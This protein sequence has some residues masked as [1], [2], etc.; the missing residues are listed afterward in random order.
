MLANTTTVSQQTS[1]DVPTFTAYASGAVLVTFGATVSEESLNRA[2]DCV[3]EATLDSSAAVVVDLSHL[4]AFPSE[5]VTA[6]LRAKARNP[7]TELS[8][9]GMEPTARG[10]LILGTVAR[11]KL[12]QLR[13]LPF[14]VQEAGE[15]PGREFRWS[16]ISALSNL[17]LGRPLEK[18]SC[19]LAERYSTLSQGAASAAPIEI[20]ALPPRAPLDFERTESQDAVSIK[21][22]SPPN[23]D[24]ARATLGTII[25]HLPDDRQCVIDIADVDAQGWD[26]TATVIMACK[27]RGSAGLPPVVVRAGPNAGALLQRLLGARS[28]AATVGRPDLGFTLEQS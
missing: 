6:L 25:R 15:K 16:A 2:L 13:L 10:T 20:P 1:R 26:I 23:S 18:E 19:E 27:T 4:S 28:G 3:Q 17:P 24:D 7:L 5:A 9:N 8:S 11:E 22:L 21:L 12:D 14:I